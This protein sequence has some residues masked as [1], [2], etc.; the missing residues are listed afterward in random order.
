MGEV[1]VWRLRSC[2]GLNMTCWVR[3]VIWED[4]GGLTIELIDVG[5]V[6]GEDV[7]EDGVGW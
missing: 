4:N 3:V 1:K 7:I 2:H 6:M 5:V